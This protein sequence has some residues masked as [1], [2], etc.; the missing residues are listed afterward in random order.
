ML[1]K[2]G[3]VSRWI[4]VF[5]FIAF[6]LGCHQS[7]SD[8]LTVKQWNDLINQSLPKGSSRSE[9]EKFLDQRGIEHSYVE[10]SNFPEEANSVI[11]LV[12][13]KDKNGIVK[14]VGIQLKF[15]FDVD[16]RLVSFES[17]EVFTGP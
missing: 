17:K 9:I 10:K 12:R 5:S 2:H 6:L 15:K 3:V 1:P 4:L 8:D 11:A 16:Q 13:A 14:K 7:K